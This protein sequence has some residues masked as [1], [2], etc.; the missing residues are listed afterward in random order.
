MTNPVWSTFM[1]SHLPELDLWRLT[2][3]WPA[4]RG[5]TSKM[6]PSKVEQGHR[7]DLKSLARDRRKRVEAHGGAAVNSAKR[8][9]LA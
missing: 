9:V 7:A 6:A 2:V 3:R 4:R 5:G 8:V 1:G